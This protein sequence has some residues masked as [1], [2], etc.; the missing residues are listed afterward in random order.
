[1]AQKITSRG[2]Y[3]YR[4]TPDEIAELSA[5]P[6]PIDEIFA[7]EVLKRAEQWLVYADEKLAGTGIRCYVSPGNDDMFELDDLMR[8]IQT[9]PTGRGRGRSQLDDDHEMISSGWSNVTPWHTYREEE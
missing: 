4:T 6:E 1:M 9:C 5:H 3:P 8:A 7:L 2:Y